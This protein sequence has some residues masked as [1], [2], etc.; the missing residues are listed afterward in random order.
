MLCLTMDDHMHFCCASS[1]QNTGKN[2]AVNNVYNTFSPQ[3][4]SAKLGC[5]SS[6]YF[7]FVQNADLNEN[8]MIQQEDSRKTILRCAATNTMLCWQLRNRQ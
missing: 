8:T 6:T 7:I 2:L 5:I 1:F 3:D 4:S